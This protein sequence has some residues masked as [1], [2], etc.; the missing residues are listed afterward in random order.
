VGPSVGLDR[1]GKTRPT[2]IRSPDRPARSES[3]D[4]LRYSG[5]KHLSSTLKNYRSVALLTSVIL[6][7][8]VPITGSANNPA[9]TLQNSTK[10]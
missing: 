6:C 9:N 10:E 4:R 5:P 8:N 1:C 3:L 2:G 7:N